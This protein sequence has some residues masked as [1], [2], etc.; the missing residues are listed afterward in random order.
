MVVLS[1]LLHQSRPCPEGGP[2]VKGGMGCLSLKLITQ[3][4]GIDLEELGQLTYETEPWHMIP[5]LDSVV[6]RGGCADRDRDLSLGEHARIGLTELFQRLVHE[7][8]S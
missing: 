6:I 7:T 8:A 5:K 2:G 1:W 3:L 4:A